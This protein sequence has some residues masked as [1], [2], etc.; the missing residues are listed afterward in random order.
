MNFDRL[1]SLFTLLLLLALTGCTAAQQ[2]QLTPVDTPKFSPAATN[3]TQE[4][5]N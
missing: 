3:L 5:L 2:D 1:F 4:T